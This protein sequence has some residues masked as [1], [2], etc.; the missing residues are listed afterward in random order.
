MNRHKLLGVAAIALLALLAVQVGDAWARAGGGGSRGS[1]S[2]S[3]PARPAPANPGFPANPSR[4]ATQPAP[5]QFQQQRPGLFG[6]LMGGLAGFA[7]GGLLGSLLFGGLGHGFGIGLMDILLIGGGLALL[8]AVLRRRRA[9]APQPAYATA[10]G[11]SVAYRP[12]P[13]AASARYAAAAP[14]ESSSPVSEL[15]RGLGHIRQLDARFDPHA[16]AITARNAFLE[17]QQ[18]IARRDVSGMRDRLT[19]EMQAVLQAQCD[20]LRGAR[21]T[22]HI[23]QIRIDRAEISEAW[24][25]SGRDYVTVCIAGSMVD[26]IA[27]DATGGVV[28][29]SKNSPQTV[30]EFWTFVRPVGSNPWQLSAIQT[31]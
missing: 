13:E 26:Y 9:E 6:G 15:E 4:S 23:E 27:D 11:P 20:R 24:Q 30:E 16:V 21:Q 29:G 17:V 22:N 2:Y 1:R 28:E 14:V 18:G 10:S 3:S 31:A 25:E 7:L 19:P 8:M 12:E 5:G